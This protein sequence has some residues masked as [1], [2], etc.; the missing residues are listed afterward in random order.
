M[1]EWIIRILEP[2]FY[3]PIVEF[4]GPFGFLAGI[5]LAMI[6]S[7]VPPLPL[8][9]FVTINV[10]IFGFVLGYVLSYVGTVTGSYLVF[11]LLQKYGSKY[12][13]KYIEKHPKAQSLFTWIHE[14]GVFP[15]FLLLTFPFTPSV[16]VG[17]LAAFA[18]IRPKDYL[19]ALIPGK[20]FMV[21]SLTI[22]GVNIQSFFE[23]PIRSVG[24][25]VLVL[26]VSLVAKQVLA[27]YERKVL[28]YRI[29]HHY[30][31]KDKK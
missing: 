15:L 10:I 12:M 2:D 16:I 7:F 25:I 20:L 1:K 24:F 28:R 17:G 22:I 29:K 4:L 8:A 19:L 27:I 21:M 30:I 9:A 5:L 26:S 18:E 31:Q 14:K 11:L 13:H 23:K 6:E 3:E